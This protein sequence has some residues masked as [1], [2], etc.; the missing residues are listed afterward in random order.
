MTCV[1]CSFLPVSSNLVYLFIH[2]TSSFVVYNIIINISH[3]NS[4]YWSFWTFF[5][6]L[7]NIAVE[8]FWMWK[9]WMVVWYAQVGCMWKRWV[10]RM[11]IATLW[12]LLFMWVINFQLLQSFCSV[13]SVNELSIFLI[14]DGFCCIII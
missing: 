4:L 6:P 5:L 14:I 9:L 2:F 1:F 7:T 11:M 13:C 10:T 3:T 12:M 8:K